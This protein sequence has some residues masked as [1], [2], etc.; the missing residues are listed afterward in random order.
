MRQDTRK[1]EWGITMRQEGGVATTAAGTSN[2]SNMT[3]S[4]G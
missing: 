1:K 2:S 4:L 3:E